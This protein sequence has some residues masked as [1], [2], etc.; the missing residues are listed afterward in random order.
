MN[1]E[2]SDLHMCLQ[3]VLS[4]S[5]IRYEHYVEGYLFYTRHFN[6]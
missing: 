6:P 5:Q 3:E 1:G 2:S 4:P